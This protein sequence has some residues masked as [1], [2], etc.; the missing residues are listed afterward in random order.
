MTVPL[1]LGK[2]IVPDFHK[3]VAVTAH[4]TVRSA[5]AVF[6][7]AVI[8]NFR[9]R[10]ARARAVLPEIITRSRLRI[11]VKPGDALRRDSD[12]PVPDRKRL[13]ILPVNRRIKPV[14]L[15]PQHFRQKLPRPRDRFL[16]KIITKRKI[17]EHFKKCQMSRRPAHILNI[18]GADTFLTCR[19]SPARR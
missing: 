11:A 8:I 19:N 4:F 18:T 12:V 10:A 9:A 5:A 13:V 15:K 17:S 3:T 16:F 1:K 6:H 2:Y 14:R 7:A